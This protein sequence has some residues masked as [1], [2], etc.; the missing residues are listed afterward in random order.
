MFV[1]ERSRPVAP[2][3]VPF[4]SAGEYITWGVIATEMGE[5]ARNARVLR[6]AR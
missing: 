1:V 2:D 4:E 3:T 6:S 5:A